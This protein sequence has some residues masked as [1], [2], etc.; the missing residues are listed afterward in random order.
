MN[1]YVIIGDNKPEE[2]ITQQTLLST[3]SKPENILVCAP[4]KIL[5][6]SMFESIY[7]RLNLIAP[8]MGTSDFIKRYISAPWYEIQL[9]TRTQLRGFVL[10]DRCLSLCGQQAD[11]IY[12]LDTEAYSAK[13]FHEK[14]TPILVTTPDS[15]LTLFFNEE[16]SDRWKLLIKDG[17]FEI[18]YAEQEEK[19]DHT[20]KIYNPY[21]DKWSW[22]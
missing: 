14:V 3:V 8:I 13:V 19:E 22:L 1:R 6:K 11:A 10:D 20:G 4:R 9:I 16:M 18:E 2:R 21:T 5:L 12:T 7:R 15:S 17:G